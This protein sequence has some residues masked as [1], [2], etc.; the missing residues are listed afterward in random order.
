M[1][2]SFY[3]LYHSH[4]LFVVLLGLNLL[5]EVAGNTKLEGQLNLEV[6]RVIFSSSDKCRFPTKSAGLDGSTKLAV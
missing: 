4:G 6:K 1:L 5:P 3:K 2:L